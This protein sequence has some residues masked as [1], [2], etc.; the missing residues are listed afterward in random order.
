MTFVLALVACLATTPTQCERVE[1]RIDR[2]G[3]VVPAQLVDW[4]IDHPDYRIT[5]WSCTL[6]ESA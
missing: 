3:V 1:F 2:C 5:R 6:G 4:I